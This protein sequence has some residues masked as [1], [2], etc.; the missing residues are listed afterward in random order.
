MAH[1]PV[2]SGWL[3]SRWSY[4]YLLRNFGA[5]GLLT[6]ITGQ[7]DYGPNLFSEGLDWYDERGI[8]T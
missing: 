6:P 8:S 4:E 1:V 3:W 5:S 2:V 7:T